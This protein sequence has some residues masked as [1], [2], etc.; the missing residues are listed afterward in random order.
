MVDDLIPWGTV[1]IKNAA[2]DFRVSR[3]RAD[4][5]FIAVGIE[6]QHV[7]LV[8]TERVWSVDTI[9]MNE[10]PIQRQESCIIDHFN[11][12]SDLYEFKFHL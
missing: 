3:Q 8:R 11:F 6:F 5:I 12:L 2:T 4:T 1:C 9:D 7:F 10:Q